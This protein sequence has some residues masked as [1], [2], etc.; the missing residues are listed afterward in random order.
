[1]LIVV[2]DTTAVNVALPTIRNQLG[3]TQSSLAWVVNAYLIS[4][5]GLL[6]LAGRLGD[7]LSRRRVFIGGLLGF[8]AASFACGVAPNQV[9]LIAARFAQ[10]V[11][12]A[13]LSAVILG[14]VVTLFPERAGRAKALGLYS[15][16]LN[17][18]GSIGLV[19]GGVLTDALN[20]HWVFFVNVPIG[21]GTALLAVRW[22]GRE[23]RRGAGAEA[24]FLGALLITVALMLGVYTIV[25]QA[26]T[27]G[28]GAPRTLTLAAAS[29]ALLVAFVLRQATT[30]NPLMPLSVLRSRETCTANLVQ[31]LLTT[32]MFGMFFLAS[33]YLQRI[34][35]FD[36][37]QIGLAFLPLTV[38]VA[39][40]SVRYSD[41]LV[42]RHG[43]VRALLPGLGLVAA[44]LFALTRCPVHGH[45]LLDLLPALLVLGVGVGLAFPAVMALAM[46]QATE[47]DA[48]LTSGL[49]NT[50]VQVSGA[51]GLGLLATLAS[52][53]THRSLHTGT[54][55]LQR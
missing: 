10:G 14:M 26:A 53:E 51:L 33:L 1:M 19:A 21:L 46:S 55:L 50:T 18:G 41:R 52:S 48:G 36:A 47:A 24:D 22:L 5:G 23:P 45:Y 7:L 35:G 8:T 34:R 25:A 49:I 16:V 31:A 13:M 27:V 43:P 3:F 17:V 37:L 2:L 28:W 54:P 20:W 9:V 11:G 39:I 38:V 12:G 32:G 4:F 29:V 44:G 42:L 15:F 6:L 30:P 40:V